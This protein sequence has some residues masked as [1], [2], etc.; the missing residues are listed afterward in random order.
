MAAQ[1]GSACPY[2]W[3]S[4][5]MHSAHI[6]SWRSSHDVQRHYISW[7]HAPFLPTIYRNTFPSDRQLPEGW[8]RIFF[9]DEII[10]ECQCIMS[11]IRFKSPAF[12]LWM[13]KIDGNG[14]RS[15]YFR[16]E[17]RN[18]W[19][20]FF[21]SEQLYAHL[22][23][24]ASEFSEFYGQMS[25]DFTRKMFHLRDEWHS[26][27]KFFAFCTFLVHCRHRTTTKK[28]RNDKLLSGKT[29]H[30]SLGS[31]HHAPCAPWRPCHR[32]DRRRR[33]EQNEMNENDSSNVKPA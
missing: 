17:I 26:V 8:L 12:F 30:E 15:R 19:S 4:T 6:S 21:S 9:F 1:I 18:L 32:C 31:H 33:W 5:H 22:R 16:T 10:V 29:E 7:T 3:R 2:L 13:N 24:F 25:I 23:P 20:D 14:H 11:R 28:K 27:F